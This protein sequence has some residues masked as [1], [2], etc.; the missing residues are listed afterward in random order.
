MAFIAHGQ[1]KDTAYL[2]LPHS[3]TAA[4][5]VHFRALPMAPKDLISLF[6]GVSEDFLHSSQ[7]TLIFLL[8]KLQY[9]RTTLREVEGIQRETLLQEPALHAKQS[10]QSQGERGLCQLERMLPPQVSQRRGP[11]D[12][13]EV[14]TGSARKR[15]FMLSSRAN[16]CE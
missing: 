10:L 4:P 13:K 2:I 8:S 15:L 3:L 1:L 7:T 12:P 5:G 6:L 11:C 16:P 9:T 14:A